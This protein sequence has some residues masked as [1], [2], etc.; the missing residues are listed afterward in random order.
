[1][2]AFRPDDAEAD[3]LLP[4]S[5]RHQSGVGAVSKKL[6]GRPRGTTDNGTEATPE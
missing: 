4:A 1:M 3:G 5:S 6:D 2:A